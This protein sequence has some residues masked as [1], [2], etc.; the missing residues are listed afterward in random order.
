M[1]VKCIILLCIIFSAD[2]QVQQSQGCAHPSSQAKPSGVPVHRLWVLH[3][4]E[5]TEGY[6][7]VG[8]GCTQVAAKTEHQMQV[9][10]REVHKSR[11]N[12]LYKY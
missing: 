3:G 6:V 12:V 9:F 4:R 11:F 5:Q 7:A 8:K 10:N 2:K 1:S